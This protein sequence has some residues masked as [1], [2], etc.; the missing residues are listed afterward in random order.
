[1][2]WTIGIGVGVGG[3]GEGGMSVKVGVVEEVSSPPQAVKANNIAKPMT[4]SLCL[5]IISPPRK[6]E[7]VEFIIS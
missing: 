4:I 1:M 3:T 2:V 7:L 5:F 6:L